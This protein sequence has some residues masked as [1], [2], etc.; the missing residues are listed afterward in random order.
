[1]SIRINVY[2]LQIISLYTFIG[3]RAFMKFCSIIGVERILPR[4]FLG[5]MHV[6]LI[7][8]M[9]YGLIYFK[10]IRTDMVAI[11]MILFIFVLVGILRHNNISAIKHTVFQSYFWLTVIPAMFFLRYYMDPDLIIKKAFP[12]SVF[13]ICVNLLYYVYCTSHGIETDSYMAFSYAQV[14]PWAFIIIYPFAIEDIPKTKKRIITIFGIIMAIAISSIGA[15]GTILCFGALL[16]FIIVFSQNDINKKIV[17]TFSAVI[18]A[19]I[20][21]YFWADIIRWLIIHTLKLGIESRTLLLLSG[22]KMDAFYDSGRG[23]LRQAALQMIE[24]HPII[25]NGMAAQELVY[26]IGNY[27]HNV[28]LNIAVDHG[29]VIAVAFTGF[30]FYMPLYMLSPK[31]RIPKKWKMLFFAFYLT[32]FPAMF[33]SGTPY[34]MTVTYIAISVYFGCRD[35]LKT[36]KGNTSV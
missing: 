31:R 4:H 9:Y 36:I 26:G 20:I 22:T 12:V 18:I 1:M 7:A 34:N 27:A 3:M 16:L 11:F 33:L 19:L 2:K 14:V 5:M 32:G 8:F 35:Y 25:G 13:T 21:Y 30:Y 23:V 17:A 24:E 15:R 29:L 6:A 28:F 10:K